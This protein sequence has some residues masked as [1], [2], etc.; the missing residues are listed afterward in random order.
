[1]TDDKNEAGLKAVAANLEALDAKQSLKSYASLHYLKLS[2]IGKPLVT[3]AC[4]N[5]GIQFPKSLQLFAN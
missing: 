4:G 5:I 3:A 2:R 1:M